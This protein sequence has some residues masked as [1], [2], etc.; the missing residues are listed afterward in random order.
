MKA[1]RP[2]SRTDD[3][4]AFST[5]FVS[6]V[7]ARFMLWSVLASLCALIAWAAV[8]E[9]DQV[10]RAPAQFIAA[11]R[12]QFVQ[13]PDAGVIT[14]IH[15]KEGDEV[16]QGQMLITLEKERAG[17]AVDDSRSKVAAL[18]AAT[19]RLEAELF[20]KPL[21]FDSELKKFPEF[22][23]N[24]RELFMRRQRAL[25]DEVS[26]LERLLKL[27]QQE[28]SIHEKLLPT[29]DVS[30]AEVLRLRKGT[31]EIL[32]QISNRK[33]KYFQEAQAELT[34]VR[35]ELNTHQEQLRERLQ[36]FE[37]TELRAPADGVINNIRATTLGAVLRP[38]DVAMEI[39]PSGGSLIAEA[40]VSPTDIAFVREGQ[41]SL[42]KVD[43][44]DSSIFGGLR[45]S[46]SYISPDVLKEE[47]KEG[48][49]YFYRVHILVRAAEFTGKRSS[50]IQLRPGMTAQVEIKAMER[51]VLSY[52]TKPI[53][54]T[55][56]ESLG[57]R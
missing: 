3:E 48:V 9:V 40:K 44:F 38:G 33:N 26:S 46:V 54:K 39:Y 37:H 50:E 31:A 21:E 16:K 52:L 20:G 36:V 1:P 30:E 14:A 7:R 19:V 55:L 23:A 47:S 4:A 32:S 34:K 5:V 29:G 41:D 45:G 11:D 6:P 13:A 18:R 49:R 8:A 24:Q 12:T 25:H 10:T 53:V 28:L 35:E 57:E 15:V 27:S 51:T 22:V 43:A 2:P 56:G 42:V 17:A